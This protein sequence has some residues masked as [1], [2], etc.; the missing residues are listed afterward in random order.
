MARV[1]ILN[2][3][4][5]YH[6]GCAAVCESLE[7]LIEGHEIVDRVATSES[8]GRLGDADLV[9]LNGEGTLHHDRPHAEK[10][11][12]LLGRAQMHGI[13]TAIVNATWD[14]MSPNWLKVVQRCDFVSA[15]EP[16]SA[17]A[18]GTENVF[19]DLSLSAVRWPNKLGPHTSRIVTGGNG[20]GK[21]GDVIGAY[22][23]ASSARVFLRK[24]SFQSVVDELA[25]ASMYLTGEYHGM[26]AA[27]AAGVS[28]MALP[29]N[30]HKIE[31][32]IDWHERS[33]ET[34]PFW[35][36]L[37]KL[38]RLTKEVLDEGLGL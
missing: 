20:A 38:P 28:C 36:W 2:W 6:A 25:G 29:S 13:K 14:S 12:G 24:R 3:T 34:Y 9:V 33:G 11:L 10:F 32:T 1:C 37:Q 16:W 4:A 30:T 35:L 15:R 18:M 27:A 23:T 17:K 19:P 26:Y 5:G 8:G 21:Y 22:R 7:R 31:A